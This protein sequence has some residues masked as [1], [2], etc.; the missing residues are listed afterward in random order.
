MVYLFCDD[1]SFVAAN[2]AMMDK[3]L[4]CYKTFT[5]RWRITVNPGKRKVMYSERAKEADIRTHLFGDTVI[6]HVKSLKSGVLIKP[7]NVASWKCVLDPK[8]LVCPPRYALCGKRLNP[9]TMV[10]AI[11][12]LINADFVDFV[13]LFRHLI[14]RPGVK[15][16]CR[17]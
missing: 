3:L 6:S 9:A 13:N 1:T 4:R 10:L 12:S 15:F 14:P 5:V 7:E 16:P 17:K 2:L 11:I 8:R